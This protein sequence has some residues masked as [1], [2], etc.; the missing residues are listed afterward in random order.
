MVL[1]NKWSWS[2]FAMVLLMI[3]DTALMTAAV[4]L[5]GDSQSGD[6]VFL[7]VT[8]FVFC[9]F[10]ILE[11]EYNRMERGPFDEQA[12]NFCRIALFYSISCLI[13]I[14]ISFLPDYARPVLLISILMTMSA[15]PFLGLLAGCYSSVLL[16][17]TA[18][19][20]IPLLSCYLLLCVC[21][22]VVTQY[23]KKKMDLFWSSFL[24]V[25]TTVVLGA[26]FFILENGAL[27]W[28]IV[29]YGI[30]CGFISASFSAVLFRMWQDQMKES[31]MQRLD[32]IIDDSQELVR[33]IKAFSQAD[34]DHARK[35]SRI[36]GECAK[37]LKL[38]EHL[39]AAAGF[40][41]RLG[42]LEG[43]PYVENGVKLAKKY[44][45]PPELVQILGEYN[46]ELYLPST[47]ESALVH[48]VDQVVTKFDVL[49]ADTLSSSWNQDIVIYQTLN[50][51][52][53]SGLYDQSGLS[54]NLFLLVRDFL[55][56]EAGLYDDHPGK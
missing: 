28:M 51:S 30:L 7:L 11:L 53:A 21:G 15:T 25:T 13:T 9:I 24:F 4:L 45:F 37:K 38:D 19:Q 55:I 43:E 52:S 2:R 47:R 44:H 22:S 29:L 18:N 34:Y 3:L 48:I 49:D 42:R 40:Y 56:K 17:C 36:A 23:M 20:S 6:L 5:R 26:S 41:Y 27:N 33:E 54:M 39:M 8:G 14:L 10:M 31:R 32:R 46:G 12:N 50:D 1:E 35:V 16:V